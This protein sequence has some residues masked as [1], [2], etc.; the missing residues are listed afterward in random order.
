[1]LLYYSLLHYFLYHIAIPPA[2]LWP[3]HCYTWCCLYSI[4]T[5]ITVL[6]PDLSQQLTSQ[7]DWFWVSSPFTTFLPTPYSTSFSS[8]SLILHM[9]Y[10]QWSP[11]SLWSISSWALYRA[12]LL[13]PLRPWQLKLSTMSWPL[14]K[15]LPLAMEPSFST[16]T[17]TQLSTTVKMT[18]VVVKL[19][20]RNTCGNLQ[21][22][23][24]PLRTT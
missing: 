21:K 4:L 15:Q 10:S 1:M 13:L 11:S 7:L 19:P 2:A 17:L 22:T 14:A 18:N 12:Y 23:V 24:I 6:N 8:I 16:K 9:C 20:I 3:C 5:C